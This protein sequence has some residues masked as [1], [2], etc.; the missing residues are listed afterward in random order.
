M[1][2]FL[3]SKRQKHIGYLL[4]IIFYSGI[5]SP[6]YASLHPYSLD[7]ENHYNT[8]SHKILKGFN[9]DK[10]N[11]RYSQAMLTESAGTMNTAHGKA[12]SPKDFPL[13]TNIGGPTQPEM[14][15]FKSVGADNMVNLFTGD[16]SYNIPLMDV[17][18]YP[19]NIF[20]NGAVSMEQ[21]AS[22][23]GLGWNINP[24]SISR[25]VRGVPDDFNGEDKMVQTQVMKPNK[26]WGVS[27][28]ADFEFSGVKTI[29]DW[30][31][32]SVAGTLGISFNNYLGPALD[33]GIKGGASFKIAEKTNSEKYSSDTAKLNVGAGINANVSSRDGFSLSPNVSLTASAFHNTKGQSIGA[34]LRLSTSYNSRHGIKEMQ[35]SEQMSFN[36]AQQN[37]NKGSSSGINENIGSSSISFAKPSYIPALR[38]PLTNTAYAGH[39]QLGGSIFGA[40]VSG[41]MEVF[42][43]TS[44]VA[45]NDIVLTKPMIGYLYYQ[46]AKSDQNAVMDFTRFNDNEV[47]PNTP[48]ISAPQYSYDIFSIQGE[49]TGGSIRPYRNDIGFVRDNLTRSQDKSLSMGVDISPPGHYGGNFS[50]IKTPSSIGE[51]EEGNKL[52]TLPGFTAADKD[53][54]NVYFRNPGES[55]VLNPNQFDR[56]GG[57]DLVRFKLSG[58]SESPRIEPILEKIDRSGISNGTANI[59]A[60][61]NAGRKKRTQVI[62]F[63]TAKE[64]SDIGLDIYIKSYNRQTILIPDALGKNKLNFTN[65]A[66]VG[67][68]RKAHHI[69]QINITEANGR[70]YIYGIPAYNTLQ[71]DFTFSVAGSEIDAGAN[72]DKVN[73]QANEATPASPHVAGN[74]TT[75]KDGYVQITATPPSAHTFLLSGL[76]SPDYVDVN[77][78]GITEDD[79]G[80]AVKFNY[81]LMPSLHKWRTPLSDGNIANLN[82]GK[83]TDSKDDKGLISYG[84]RESW[85]VHS[86]ESKTMIALF[87]LENRLDGKGALNELSGIDGNDNSQQLLRKIDLY[88]KADIR[89]NGLT[90]V[91]KARPIKT[92][93]FVYDYTLCAGSPDYK[94]AN[95]SNGKLTLKSIWFSFNNQVRA[96]KNQYVFDYGT[97]GQGNPNYAFNASD[98]W[99]TYKSAAGNPAGLKNS[100]YPFSIQDKAQKAVIDQN[101]GAWSLKKILLPSGGQIEVNYESKD[102]A[103]VQDKRAA[104]MTQVVGLGHDNNLANKTS[105]LYEINGVNG[106]NQLTTITENDYVFIK[107][108]DACAGKADVLSKYLRGHSQLAFRLAV[109]MPNGGTEYITSYAAIDLTDP[110]N[111]GVSLTDPNTIWVKVSEV[112]SLSPLSLTAVEF[113]R[114]QLPAQAFKG[115]DVSESSTLPQVGEM[116]IGMLDALKNAFTDPVSSIRNAGGA[117]SLNTA[118]SFVRLNDP[119][120]FKYGGG[121]RVKSVILKDNWQVMKAAAGG[122]AGQFKSMYGQQYDYTTTEIFEGQE[123][124]ISSGVATYEPALGGDENPF[125]TI[126]QVANKLP[127]GPASYGS[128]EMPVLDAFFPAASI[129][130][131]KVTVRSVRNSEIPVNMKPRS[132]VGK[133]VNEFYTAKDYPVYYQHTS[134]D[135]ASDMQAHVSPQLAFF[136][137]YAFDSRA[138]S[139]GFLVVNNDMH[140]KMK[141]QA[142]YPENDD[143]TFINYTRHFYRNTGDKGVSETF[144]FVS[145]ANQGE[146]KSGNMGIDVELMTDTR[147][148]TVK[149][150]SL[151][152]QG[153]ADWF[154]V[155]SGLPWLP[156]IW[157][158]VNNSENTYRAVTTTK[159]ISFHSVLDS[160]MVIEKGSQAG[161]KNLVFDAETGDVIVN[162]TNNE[163]NQPVYSTSYPAYWAYGGMGLAYKNIDAIYTANFRDGVI[164]GVPAT[165]FESGDELYVTD[166]GVPSPD[167][168][169]SSFNTAPAMMLWAFD[170]GKN[171]NSLVN[172]SPS[173]VFMDAVGK[174]FSRNN[175]RFKIVRSGKRNMLDAKAASVASMSSPVVLVAPNIRKLKLDIN[176]RSVNAS[177]IEYK[178]KWQVDNDVM[179]K[180]SSPDCSGTEVSDCNGYLEKHINPY[181]KGLLGNFRAYQN[182]VFYD[183]RG[184][185]AENNLISP[186]KTNIPV[187]GYLN[188]FKLYWDFNTNSNLVPDIA[189]TKQWV[190]N[191]QNTRVNAKGLELETRDALDIY[192]SAQYGFNKTVPVAISN[193][194]RYNEMFAEGFEDYD[195][196]EGINGNLLNSCAKRHAEFLNASTPDYPRILNTENLSFNAHSGR[197]VL[198]ISPNMAASQLSIG[199]SSATDYYLPL[200]YGS[201][202][203]LANRGGNPGLTNVSPAF[204]TSLDPA[205]YLS[206]N[207]TSTSGGFSATLGVANSTQLKTNGQANFLHHLQFTN[208]W[209]I[210]VPTG[211]YNFGLTGSDI[212]NS[213]TSG[214]YFNAQV[215]I[216]DVN[217]NVVKYY[218]STGNAKLNSTYSQVYLCKGTYKIKVDIL[219]HFDYDIQYTGAFPPPGTAIT[220]L[221]NFTFTTNAPTDSYKDLASI[222]GCNFTLPIAAA[223]SMINPTF[224]IPAGKQMLFSAWVREDCG[225]PCV[226]KTYTLNQV[227][228]QYNDG[229]GAPIT[230]SP[231]GPII[232]GWQRYEGVIPIAPATAT[233]C[234]LSFVNNSTKMVYF[235]DIRI[236]PFNANMKSYVYDPVNLR[237]T[238]ELDANNYAKFYEYD[239][240][241]TLIRTKAETREGIKTITETRSATQTVIKALVP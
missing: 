118:Q 144:D 102:Y 107:V 75:N 64:A 159:V 165:A 130:F 133:Q 185:T 33:L 127:L 140:G 154:P 152:I 32:L 168:C 162:R 205:V 103:F 160:V 181:K 186:I 179:Y 60:A 166:Q 94:P 67:S 119:D 10:Q 236:H 215:Y 197:Y 6:A 171:G 237:L 169:A 68:Y 161:T 90:G 125:H 153:Q 217:N 12:R 88:S 238:A 81:T 93:N 52:K 110:L 135:P 211:Y 49:G 39:V 210:Q 150:N 91:N 111:Y 193:N 191:N 5:V 221:Y 73:F 141:S 225:N 183:G 8:T 62:S 61:D 36:K 51:W 190:W 124:T 145:P 58:P 203:A 47:T 158:V 46:N 78:D 148:F 176:S 222:T 20:Y 89:K 109:I 121:Q 202:T 216:Y 139:Q 218:T 149:S 23:V 198:G 99:G 63:L 230:F 4:L 137:K 213:A 105:N 35:I 11:N 126:V 43:Q 174:L 123:R 226:Q 85:Y 98:R 209:F 229:S 142:S 56:I 207:A 112:N 219:N 108:A 177:A 239:P 18:G 172:P 3:A 7:D 84:E 180:L 70:R 114:Q 200:G 53:I 163:F 134:F 167:P 132:G 66:R 120:G 96:R 208:N 59:S 194:A 113:L 25:N 196:D 42:K 115:Y 220:K 29:P 2:Q 86:I 76:L 182:K 138:L 14:T 37:I 44:E 22:W 92:V 95:L 65:I 9:N 157:P 192:T 80:S 147:Q 71:K 100:D 143:K 184:N 26:T 131:S 57:L 188:N 31:N 45:D 241:G 54:E 40:H 97:A 178:E 199:S 82:A 30:L 106:I 77:G 41:E 104:I 87:T 69:S 38:M 170:Q 55:S 24:G 19:I 204:A 128:I 223:P 116:L 195:Y 83:R 201:V 228:F 231:S 129:G 240:E 50:T 151:E 79:L 234:A 27:L 232:E 164:S 146:I 101:A 34:G 74:S 15:S 173:L 189:N 227:K 206:Q 13:E 28:G 224:S 235:D 21:E 117:Q 233:S 212:T 155:F 214:D 136:Y 122:A 187:N 72:V 48:I 156:F 175:V 16:F 1:I 17:G